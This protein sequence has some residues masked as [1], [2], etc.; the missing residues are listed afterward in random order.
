MLHVAAEALGE[1]ISIEA[2][3]ARHAIAI[4]VRRERRTVMSVSSPEGVDL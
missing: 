4:E 1:V 2:L 3:R